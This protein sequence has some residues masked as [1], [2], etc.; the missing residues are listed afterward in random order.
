MSEIPHGC[1]SIYKECIG[2]L[3]LSQNLG[4]HPMQF[5]SSISKSIEAARITSSKQPSIDCLDREWTLVPSMQKSSQNQTSVSQR[6]QGMFIKTR[7]G[8]IM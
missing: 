6:G 4:G 1:I 5:S 7:R 8:M 3:D 2:L